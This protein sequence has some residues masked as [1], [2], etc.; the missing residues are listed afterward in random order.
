[1]CGYYKKE[2]V[3]LTFVYFKEGC[4][5]TCTR[6]N[7]AISPHLDSM[8]YMH[9]SVHSRIAIQEMSAI[10]LSSCTENFHILFEGPRKHF[11]KCPLRDDEYATKHYKVRNNFQ[12]EQQPT[13]ILHKK[14][15]ETTLALNYQFSVF[16]FQL[17]V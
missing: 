2:S 7:D 11:L 3:R 15:S 17:S 13:E 16:R 5:M 4:G 12:E 1:M 9:K 6:I 10:R 8:G 14:K